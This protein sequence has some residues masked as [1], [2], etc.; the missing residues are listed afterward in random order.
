LRG[1]TV[2]IRWHPGFELVV[3]LESYMRAKVHK[4]ADLGAPWRAQ[5]RQGL[6]KDL[7]NRLDSISGM[8]DV[9][10]LLE[11]AHCLAWLCPSETYAVEDFL[12]WASDADVQALG[13][14]V[15]KLAGP[16][17][18]SQSRIEEMRDRTVV[19]LREWHRH[20]F[21]QIDTGI[22]TGLSNEA[23]R[24][25]QRVSTTD[26]ELLVEE[27][28]GG[29]VLKP[30]PSFSRVLMAPQYHAR[31]WNLNSV[32]MGVCYLL[33]P[34]E[35]L[36]A[37]DGDPPIRLVRLAKALDDRSRLRILRLVAEE[38]LSL[39]EIAKRMNL[40]K[41]TVHYHLV[42]LRAAG[43]LRVQTSFSRRLDGRYFLRRSALSDLSQDLESF[44]G[45]VD[46]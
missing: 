12:R 7:A 37:A 45:G 5:V 41:P 17:E 30:A 18:Q 4:V 42:L 19:L 20:Y 16:A 2:E 46:V 13:C 39:T 44:L 14:A 43:L 27:L 22:L 10:L 9:G 15:A 3:S 6:P 1:Y 36:A 34:A 29:I 23:R 32:S 26:P 8:R 38:P 21:S 24:Q 25:G 11:T 31:P 40:T 28:S 33:Y 35:V